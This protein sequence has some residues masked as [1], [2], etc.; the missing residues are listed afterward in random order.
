MITVDN[1]RCE[2]CGTC[3]GVCPADALVIE[4]DHLRFAAEM[5]IECGACA[6]VCPVEAIDM[7]ERETGR[8]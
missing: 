7:A 6:A 8:V 4:R 3:V 2:L 5:C 1:T